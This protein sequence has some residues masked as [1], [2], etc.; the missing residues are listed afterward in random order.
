MTA[1]PFALAGKVAAVTGAASGLGRA[2]VEAMTV[3]GAAVA[4]IDIDT[5]ANQTSA[6]RA[7]AA[8]FTADVTDGEALE[9]VVA[10]I[11]NEVGPID[12][13]VN[14]A[15]VAG[16]GAAES[17]DAEL[18]DSILA[19]NLKGTLFACQAVGRRLLAAGRGGSII[20]IASIGGLVAYPG[21][22]GYQASKGAVVQMTRTLAVE[23]A[24]AGIRVNAVAPGHIA[25]EMVQQM[26][27]REPEL[28]EFFLS[29]TPMSQLG[30]PIDVA[31]PVV[32]LASDAAAMI[33]GQILAIDGGYTAQ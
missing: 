24:P 8:A 28:K 15:G 10:R 6:A 1:D 18:L 31:L 12:V 32:F 14:S 33:T 20:N 25:T 7:G 2:I 23:W 13:L 19:A 26:W 29:R 27:T 11:E 16:R 17:F 30:E 5:A 4:A 21:S 3:A 9:A 22:V